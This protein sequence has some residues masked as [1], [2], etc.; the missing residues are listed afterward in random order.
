MRFGSLRVSSKNIV[1]VRLCW[2]KGR[3]QTSKYHS[4]NIPQSIRMLAVTAG[5]AGLLC[6]LLL[7]SGNSLSTP[8]VGQAAHSDTYRINGRVTYAF[9]DEPYPNV[10]LS[11]G[12]DV[13]ATTNV[14]GLFELT[15]MSAGVYTVVVVE[16]NSSG[17]L[18]VFPLSHTVQVPPDALNL[19]FEVEHYVVDYGIGGRVYDTNGQPLRDVTVYLDQHATAKTDGDGRYHFFPVG[20]GEHAL[21]PEMPGYRFSPSLRIVT[22]PE[23]GNSSLDFA[24]SVEHQVALPMVMR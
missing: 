12:D 20:P 19:L 13:T 10:T 6:W 18:M 14:D 24:A 8:V 2:E 23:Q 1:V 9:S 4:M 15:V 21:W 16:A 7:L 22:L 5:L 3:K 17:S 11:A